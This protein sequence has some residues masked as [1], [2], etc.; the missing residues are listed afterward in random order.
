MHLFFCSIFWLD[1]PVLFYADAV[2]CGSLYMCCSQSGAAAAAAA[3][4]AAN[5]AAAAAAAAAGIGPRETRQSLESYLLHWLTDIS[6][7][8]LFS[9]THSICFVY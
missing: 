6:T 2:R 9:T 4:A 8:A 5:A 7:L 1:A 3:T